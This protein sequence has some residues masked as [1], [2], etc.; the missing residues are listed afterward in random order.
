MKQIYISLIIALFSI[1][2]LQAQDKKLIDK[3]IAQVGSE[4][5]L[6]SDVENE[7]GFMSAS[8]ENSD[9]SMKC[10]IL[11]QIMASKILVTQAKLDSIEASE[12]EIEGQ[13]DA[14]MDQIL[15]QMGGDE[16]M[17]Q[18][19][20]GKTVAEMK[21]IYRDDIKSKILTD[22]MQSQ[23]MANIQITPSEVVS[24]FNLIPADSLPYFN[25]EVEVGEILFIPEVNK[26]EKAKAKNKLIEIRKQIVE[27]S[28]D[29]ADLAKKYSDDYS[30]GRSGGDLGWQ[31]RGTFVPEFD[32]T[33]YSLKKGE[34]SDIVETEFGFHLIQLIERRGN[35]INAR[36]ILI[37]PEITSADIELSRSN[38][39]SIRN[40]IIEN[41]MDFGRAVKIYSDKNATSYHNNGRMTNQVN[42]STFFE[43]KDLTPE[44]YFAIEDLKVGDYSEVIEITGQTGETQFQLVKLISKTKPHK[45]SL[46]EDY[47]KIQNYA[48]ESKKNEYINKWLEEK[49]R[50]NYIHIDD[51]YLKLCPDLE[52]WINK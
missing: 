28:I 16:A 12:D 45:A 52:K 37:K 3:V 38:L 5:I 17:F 50:N 25:S 44:I 22:K 4:L 31:K 20:Y 8:Q 35:T 41:N 7:Y 2:T 27:D 19:Y 15:R 11:E 9:E 43:T 32:A 14:R 10:R 42:Q 1:V 24:F 39:D 34:L 29:F 13:L 36:H 23:L 33:A 6:M 49:I 51:K 26:E 21:N 30:S 40:L 48:K 47:S 18:S 46:K